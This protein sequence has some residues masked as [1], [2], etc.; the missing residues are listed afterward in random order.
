MDATNMIESLRRLA[1][2]LA[3]LL[4]NAD[5]AQARW[6]PAPGKW[7]LLELAGHLL[8]EEREDFRLRLELTLRDPALDW[9][10]IHP[11]RWVTERR[12]AER[13]LGEV[14]AA[15]VAHDLLHLRQ[16]ARLHLLWLKEQAAPYLME[17]AG[18]LD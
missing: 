15:W 3:A 2:P 4:E 12:Y 5:E 17:Y 13:D 8:D 16:A 1:Q 14:V 11:G 18:S 6:R 10:P 7:S 9:P